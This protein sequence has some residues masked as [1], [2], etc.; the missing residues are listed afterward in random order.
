MQLSDELKKRLAALSEDFSSQLPERYREIDLA[1][2]ELKTRPETQ[3]VMKL[4]FMIHKLAGS[5]ATFGYDQLSGRAKEFENYLDNIIR[6]GEKP[7]KREL[8]GIEKHL[9]FFREEESDSEG[10]WEELEELEEEDTKVTGPTG[11]AGDN[12]EEEEDES[13]GKEVFLFGF[14]GENKKDISRQLGFYGY[15]PSLVE[16][17]HDAKELLE[18][19]KRRVFLLDTGALEDTDKE[20]RTLKQSHGDKFKMV[21]VSDDDTFDL[22]LRAI[23]AGGDAFFVRPLDM[24]RVIDKLDSMAAVGKKEPFHILII[25]DDQEQVS[26]YALILQQ[27]GMITSVASDPMKVLSILVESRPDLI[28]M[29]IYMPGCSGIEL[30]KLLRQH[31]AFITIPIIFLSLENNRDRQM[32]AIGEGGDD[33]IIKPIS[34]DYLSSMVQLRAQRNRNLRYFMERDSLTGLLNHSNLKEQLSRE[35]MRAE[36]SEMPVSFAM[37]DADHFKDVND[38]HGHLTGDR[39]LKS[40]SRMLQD[41]LRRTDII[42]RYGGEEFGIILINTDSEEAKRIMDEIRENFAGV[43]HHSEKKGFFVTF[44]CGIASYPAIESPEE[45]NLAADEAL[46]SAKEAGR[47]RVVIKKS[48]PK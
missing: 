48:P 40:L 25:D 28:L 20:L 44:S 29:D 1:F 17:I 19:K 21:F 10:M 4:R 14:E 47:N 32:E 33:F 2:E 3:A 43:R 37:I 23:R 18:G 15:S 13:A 34:P 24:G 16:T 31:E 30:T 39:V 41:R 46:Y 9:S 6:T 22:R 36:R 35:I 38:T 42:G 7:K 26:Y 8:E 45:I 27:A 11:D 5:A 12:R